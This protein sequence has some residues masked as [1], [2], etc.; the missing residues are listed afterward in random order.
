[1]SLIAEQTTDRIAGESGTAPDPWRFRPNLLIDLGDDPAF[2]ELAWIGR[3]LRV[4]ERA[5]VAVTEPDKRCVMITL[6]PGA[7]SEILRCVARQHQSLAG[8]YGTVV[9]PG[10]VRTGDSIFLEG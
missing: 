1:M 10:E 4:G 3:I 6:D 2:G 7:E 5:R 9:A 8:V